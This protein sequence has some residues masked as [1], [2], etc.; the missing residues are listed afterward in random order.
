[1]FEDLRYGYFPDSDL[2]KLNISDTEINKNGVFNKCQIILYTSPDMTSD[3]AVTLNTSDKTDPRLIKSEYK[4]NDKDNY[5]FTF[6]A[7]GD[8]YLI[9]SNKGGYYLTTTSNKNIIGQVDSKTIWKF[10]NVGGKGKLT[11]KLYTEIQNKKLYMYENGSNIDVSDDTTANTQWNFGFHMFGDIAFNLILKANPYLIKQCCNTK[12][13]GSLAKI[14][15]DNKFV[16]GNAVCDAQL[17]EMYDV[18]DEEDVIEFDDEDYGIYEEDEM[19]EDEED[20]MDEDED[21]E[22]MYEEEDEDMYEE[23]EDMY[24]E[25]EE[26]D[27][28]DLPQIVVHNNSVG[29][30]EIVLGI[31]LIVLII[32]S[33]VLSMKKYKIKRRKVI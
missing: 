32:V 4:N 18:Y 27:M 24:E 1:M 15:K 8:G 13:T 7:S 12:Y 30:P 10:A 19:D 20:N 5:I 28:Y 3:S 6:I 21:E 2:S 23:E 9:Q 16:D 29:T 14:C 33:I 17:D 31:G 11:G 25:E 26:E 22:D